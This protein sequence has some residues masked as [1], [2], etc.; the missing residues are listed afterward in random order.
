MEEWIAKDENDYIKKT[1]TFSENKNYLIKLKSEL[2]NVA[3]KSPLFDTKKFNDN[4]YEMLLS[5]K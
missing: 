4:F 5:I 3:L 1:I 2:R